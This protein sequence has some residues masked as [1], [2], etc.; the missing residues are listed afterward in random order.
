MAVR[1]HQHVV[2]DANPDPAP[3][4]VDVL[5]VRRHVQSRLD[6]EDHALPQQA[7]RAVRFEVAAAVVDVEPQPVAGAVDRER[8]VGAFFEDRARVALQQPEPEQPFD[9]VLRGHVVRLRE[10]GP[11]AHR[12]DRGLLRV[13]H[14]VVEGPLLG[15][16]AAVDREGARDVGSVEIPLAA[17]VDQEQLAG[18]QRHVVLRVVQDARVRSAGD[19]V[20]VGGSRA[21]APAEGVVE[22]R[23]D[24]ALVATRSR[25][26][27]REAMGFGGHRRSFAHRVQ[28]G[29]SLHQPLFVQP[30]AR[31]DQLQ[32]RV[33]CFLGASTAG[34]ALGLEQVLVPL[35]IVALAV[36]DRTV[37]GQQSG[38]LVPE[39]VERE[40]Q[41][42][43]QLALRAFDPQ[44][45]AV[46]HLGF[47]VLGADEQGGALAA[48]G[49][50]HQHALRLLESGQVPEVARGSE[51][52]LA[53]VVAD[54]GPASRDHGAGA[55]LGEAF[56]E[57]LAMVCVH[58]GK[59]GSGRETGRGPRGLRRA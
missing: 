33:R 31:V 55:L 50:Q 1:G 29:R 43:V 54:P 12:R 3:A 32:R 36:D 51:A 59:G 14:D 48:V 58:V 46:P 30:Q 11:R 37:P 25:F 53:V 35:R 34:R 23:I 49:R 41:V 16:E 57:A 40:G 42:D 21:A 18:N 2:L 6:R 47:R 38:Q 10:A 39:V 28:L 13:E 24:L 56:E 7:G 20:R 19:D 15:R 27:H 5:V 4:R 44:P 22:Q 9:E 8:C 45:P 52:E 26:R 17:G